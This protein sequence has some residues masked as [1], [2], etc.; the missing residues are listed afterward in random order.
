MPGTID[1]HAKQVPN[2]KLYMSLLIVP[3]TLAYCEYG[4]QATKIMKRIIG[5]ILL[6]EFVL[7][8]KLF[9]EKTLNSSS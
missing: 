9:P 2:K 8:I 3:F 1:T 6:L 5:R 4:N 7:F